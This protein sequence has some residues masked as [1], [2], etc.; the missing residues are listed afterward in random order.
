MINMQWISRR[1]AIRAAA[2][3][4]AFV[5]ITGT[6]TS[7][8]LVAVTK[9]P[10]SAHVGSSA[11]KLTQKQ[12][13]LLFHAAAKRIVSLRLQ[14]VITTRMYMSKSE[15]EVSNKFD[16]QTFPPGGWKRYKKQPPI[17]GWN[18]T[19]YSTQTEQVHL[20]WD[21][22]AQ[23]INARNIMV[24]GLNPQA[25]RAITGN[26]MPT[27][28][29]WVV[30]R[31]L[32]WYAYLL[33]GTWMVSIH[34]RSGVRSQELQPIRRSIFGLSTLMLAVNPWVLPGIEL[35]HKHR[36]LEQKY[37]PA[38]G[39]IELIYR[40]Y[41]KN[42][43]PV[44]VTLKNGFRG[45]VEEHYTMTLSNGLR[46]YRRVDYLVLGSKRKRIREFDFRKQRKAGGVWFPTWIRERVW[47]S[48]LRLEIDVIMKISQLM[49]NKKFPPGTFRY[50]PPF[51]ASVYDGLTHTSYYVGSKNPILPPAAP[52]VGAG[53]KGGGR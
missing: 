49:V 31:R 5:V 29:I 40:A 48:S 52:T 43:K 33:N 26:T 13:R 35:P 24:Q 36:L 6:W 11:P 51:G 30:G 50:S 53:G 3:I 22:P 4:A 15:L 8:D 34:R 39:R 32:E 25:Q 21:I 44:L 37:N 7:T 45:Q 41:Y 27:I 1:G 38:T 9:T 47:G 28:G 10:V 17:P 19:G 18:A 2:A 23:M 16:K 46:V 42:G 12:W 14:A 20:D